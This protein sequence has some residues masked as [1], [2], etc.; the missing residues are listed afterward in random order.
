MKAKILKSTVKDCII[1]INV[2]KEEIP[3]A[4]NKLKSAGFVIE[5]YYKIGDR[6][7]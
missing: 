2:K 4:V 3:S 5:D 7:R 1:I 6:E